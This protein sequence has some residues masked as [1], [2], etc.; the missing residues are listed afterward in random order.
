MQ[1][2]F[3]KEKQEK[4]ASYA[5]SLKS[6]DVNQHRDEDQLCAWEKVAFSGLIFTTAYAVF[7][8]AKITLIFVHTI[9]K[10]AWKPTYIWCFLFSLERTSCIVSIVRC[11][12]QNLFFF[13]F[14]FR[15][16]IFWL[17]DQLSAKLT[18]VSADFFNFWLL[19]IIISLIV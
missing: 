11:T 14:F 3:V 6:L 17:E 7:I 19:L 8:T 5:K 13:F 18:G 16:S 4:T 2:R 9:H 10:L 1:L 12:I 15:S